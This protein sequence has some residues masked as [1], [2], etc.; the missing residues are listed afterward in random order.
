MKKEAKN[1]AKQNY[2]NQEAYF[3]KNP[4]SIEHKIWFNQSSNCWEGGDPTPL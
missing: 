4:Y 3:K 1:I 2:F